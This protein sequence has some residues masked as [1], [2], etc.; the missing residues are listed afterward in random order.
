MAADDAGWLLRCDRGEVR[1]PNWGRTGPPRDECLPDETTL[2]KCS[3][4]ES[5]TYMFSSRSGG[6]QLVVP[7]EQW[8]NPSTD[9]RH[10][11]LLLVTVLSQN[12]VLEDSKHS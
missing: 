8:T 9:V 5:M 11:Q 1:R 2:P 3:R 7:A 4:S 6:L 10:L 12:D